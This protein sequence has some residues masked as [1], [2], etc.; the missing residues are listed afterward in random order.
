LWHRFK[1]VSA[2][3][4]FDDET[5]LLDYDG[6]AGELDMRLP[7]R[8]LH[9]AFLIGFKKE[10]PQ[11]AGSGF[12]VAVPGAR[13]NSHLYLVTAKHLAERMECC[14][15]IMG[16]SYRDGSK[17][18]VEAD[19]V[20]WYA[21]PTEAAAVDVAATPFAPAQRDQ[22]DLEPV[23]EHLFSS[24]ERMGKAS[25]GVGDEI[26]AIG[27][28]TRF[29]YEDRHLPIV[30]TGNL[31]MLPTLRIPVKNF[32]PMEAYVAEIEGL[33]GSPLWVRPTASF[34]AGQ[35]D[36]GEEKQSV[37]LN[38]D[39]EM[40][41]LGL[42]HGRWEIGERA[43]QGLSAQYTK[44]MT[45]G[46]SIIVPAHKILEVINQPELAAMRKKKDEEPAKKTS[47]NFHR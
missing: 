6:R 47:L 29:S 40:I 14:P 27:M 22:L 24:G 8:I 42:L 1:L 12:V 43:M 36:G 4:I 38:G 44:N 13:A 11:Y 25:I 5:S 15:I 45:S 31:A 17:A 46:M 10:T 18:L 2:P 30:R 7:D 32:E 21:H 26:T 37:P 39:T 33:S 20:H 3:L 28:F 16:F 19:D 34:N 23:P 41:F 9:T 35:K